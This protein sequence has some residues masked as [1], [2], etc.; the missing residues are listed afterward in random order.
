MCSSEAEL[1]P[2]CFACS[3]VLVPRLHRRAGA[4]RCKIERE[5]M[6]LLEGTLPFIGLTRTATCQQR[7]VSATSLAGNLE[8]QRLGLSQTCTVMLAAVEASDLERF[9]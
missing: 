9:G 4:M 5:R 3:H 8:H 7:S 6:P 2:L 1:A